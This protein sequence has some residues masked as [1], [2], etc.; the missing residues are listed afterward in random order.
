MWIFS[1]PNPKGKQTG[2]CVIRAIAIATEK[3][4]RQ[5][6]KELSMVGYEECEMMNSNSTWGLYLYRLGF[7]PFLISESCPLCVTVRAFCHMYPQGTYIIGT[8][9]HAVAVMNGDYY[10]SWD[11]GD[12]VPSY[13]WKKQDNKWR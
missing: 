9:D 1:N 7:Q 5:V 13:F 10:D 8:G 12:T 3:D 11:S 2:D 6:Y 4:W